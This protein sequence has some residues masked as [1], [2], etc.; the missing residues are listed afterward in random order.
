MSAPLLLPPKPAVTSLSKTLVTPFPQTI[1]IRSIFPNSTS[2]THQA[3]QQ[4]Q[5]TTNL[6]SLPPQLC[7]STK[8]NSNLHEEKEPSTRRL[9][10]S[11]IHKYNIHY[12]KLSASAIIVN[13][14]RYHHIYISPT[15][16]EP[17]QDYR[18]LPETAQHIENG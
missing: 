2:P 12:N 15:P 3:K 13:L 11:T 16:R 9:V 5:I 7:A 18:L 14:L 6:V 10:Y 17:L 8:P 4:L 1:L